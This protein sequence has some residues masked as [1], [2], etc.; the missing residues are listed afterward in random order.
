MNAYTPQDKKK[1][2]LAAISGIVSNQAV[3]E[4]VGMTAGGSK[5]LRVDI[6]VS[7]VTVVGSITAKL[8]HRCNGS[9]TYADLAGA[10]A[11]VSI[12]AAGFVSLTQAVERAADQANMPL[13]SLVRV[14]LTT[15]NAGDAVTVDNVFFCQEL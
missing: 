4:E 12:S 13:K 6:K 14:V 2:G 10:N 3:S 9:D 11:S 1:I 7:G 15:T 8:Q 5:H